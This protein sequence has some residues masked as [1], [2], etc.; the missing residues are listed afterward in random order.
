[1]TFHVAVVANMLR[2]LSSQAHQALLGHSHDWHIGI[3]TNAARI[4]CNAPSTPRIHDTYSNILP[5]HF[6]T[7]IQPPTFGSPMK[8][9]STPLKSALK[10]PS[11]KPASGSS[12]RT[13][14]EQKRVTLDAGLVAAAADMSNTGAQRGVKVTTY[15]TGERHGYD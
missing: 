12:F 1:M 11:S 7:I 13:Q 10:K 15:R 4:T 6:S 9:Q 3:D 5:D 2:L 8:Q 14:T